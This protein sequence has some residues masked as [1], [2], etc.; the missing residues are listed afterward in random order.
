MSAKELATAT[1]DYASVPADTKGKL[2]NLAAQVKRGGAKYIES[3][4]DIGEALHAA[5]EELA[6]VGRDGKFGEWLESETGLSRQTASNCI[7]VY[8]RSKKFKI[9]GTFPPTVAYLLSAPETPDAAIKEAE[10]RV[11]KGERPRV[12]WAKEIVDR[13]REI[14]RPLPA[15]APPAATSDPIAGTKPEPTPAPTAEPESESNECKPGKH[16]W[17]DEDDCEVCHVARSVVEPSNVRTMFKDF[18]EH[19]RQCILLSDK[20]N[21]ATDKRFSKLNDDVMT[22]LDIAGRDAKKWRGLC[23]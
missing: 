12:K 13:L 22:S 3:V 6:G 18:L 21:N 14:E 10:K 20:I 19:L 5:H 15:K 4:V 1:F 11:G 9:L 17:N 2:I 8:E 16:K 23:K 7:H